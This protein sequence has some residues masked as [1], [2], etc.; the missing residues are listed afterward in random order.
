MQYTTR[1]GDTFAGI[2]IRL[3]NTGGD[4]GIVTAYAMGLANQAGIYQDDGVT[5][6]PQDS[7]VL[8]GVTFTIPDSWL[9]AGVSSAPATGEFSIGGFNAPQLILGGAVLWI[10]IGALK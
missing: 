1:A 7:E 6:W 5:P 9:R 4:A 3:L 2:A 8:P 10:L